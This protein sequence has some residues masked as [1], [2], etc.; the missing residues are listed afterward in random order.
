MILCPKVQNEKTG[1]V[2]VPQATI[3]NF[4][5]QKYI[6]E[7]LEVVNVDNIN[8]QSSKCLINFNDKIFANG[9]K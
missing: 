3:K 9:L 8:T 4:S 1:K 5:Y 7:H 6:K 2:S